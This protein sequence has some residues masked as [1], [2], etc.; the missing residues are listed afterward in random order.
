MRGVVLIGSGA[1]GD[2]VPGVSDLDVAVIAPAAVE[3]PEALVAPLRH[4]ELPCP[5]RKLELVVYRTEQAALPTRELELELDLNTGADGERLLTEPG[6]APAHWYLI[7]LAVARERGVAVAGPPPRELIGEP[8]RDDVLDAL[9]AGIRWSIDEEP[10]SPN[11]VLNASRA[12]HFALTGEWSSKADAADWAS[13]TSSD[14]RLPQTA[15]A[16]RLTRS[17]RI[18]AGL[19]YTEQSEV[20]TERVVQFA[21]EALAAVEGAR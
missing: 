10:G 8:P 16:A 19:T 4:T 18:R 5:A 12:A 3:E 9:A 7:D 17:E 6:D 1:L 21:E 11:T 15:L 13:Q 20:P 14:P 2:Y